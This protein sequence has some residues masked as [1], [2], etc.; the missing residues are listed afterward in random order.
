MKSTASKVLVSVLVVSMLFFTPMVRPANAGGIPVIDIAGLA[1]AIMDY[2]QNILDYYE[3]ISQLEA[4]EEQLA[5]AESQLEAITTARGLAG[6]LS[7]EYDNDFDVEY[8]DLLDSYGIQSSD[9]F[10]LT[11]EI[12]AL[13]DKKNRSPA[14]WEARSRKYCDQ[15]VDRFSELQ[16]L[17]NEVNAADDEKHILDLQAR[18]AGEQAMLENETIKL[19]MMESEAKAQQAMLRQ[20]ELNELLN[21]E[22]DPNNYRL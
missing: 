16:K 4:L 6:M 3:Q 15:A 8:G 5:T 13:Y 21:M 10:D 11:G 22:G 14:E 19:Q 12:A 9:A 18:I 20:K 1:Q 7:T 2:V 17:I